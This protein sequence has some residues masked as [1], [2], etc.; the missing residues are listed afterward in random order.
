M[1]ERKYS[2]N[3]YQTPVQLR[4]SGSPRHTTDQYKARP[5][6]PVLDEDDE[7]ENPDAWTT[8]THTSAIRRTA[9]LDTQ[10][11]KKTRRIPER[12]FDR[13]TL[14]ILVSLI[15]IVMVGGWW[16]LSMISTW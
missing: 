6:L 7:E 1:S 2:G 14:I 8:K 13:S 10:N 15:I 16:L 12:R 5:R 3:P 11:P 9:Y 4:K